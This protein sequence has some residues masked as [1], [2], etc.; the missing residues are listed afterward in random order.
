MGDAKYM[1]SLSKEWVLYT[2]RRVRDSRILEGSRWKL[3]PDKIAKDH[4]VVGPLS[5]W[6]SR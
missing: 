4:E 6:R 1:V 2:E 3:T 5:L